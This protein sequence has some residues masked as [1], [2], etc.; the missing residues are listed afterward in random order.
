MRCSLST[1]VGAAARAAGQ[2]ETAFLH[3]NRI[4]PI[5][6]MAGIPGK[7]GR[8]RKRLG[9]FNR[10]RNR[11]WVDVHPSNMTITETSLHVQ[12]PDPAEYDE[13]KFRRG[14]YH[15]AFNYLAWKKGV[16]YSLRSE[17]DDV[18]RYIRC[19]KR[20]E[21]WPYAQVQ[22]PDDSGNKKLRLTLLEDA[23]GCVVRFISFLDEFYVD[24]L[25][26]GKLH[27][28]A[29]QALPDGTGLL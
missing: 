9:H 23:P 13:L 4:W 5:L 11:I 20:G 10:E 17:F 18:R 25:G 16:D 24:L 19:A 28:W 7:K 12:L 27:S 14:L 21:V 1:H 26:S 15:M 2:L 22:F 29:R 6:I 3:H 8:P